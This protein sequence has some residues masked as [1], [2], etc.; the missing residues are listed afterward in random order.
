MDW[1]FLSGGETSP[2]PRRNKAFRLFLHHLY[3]FFN[4]LF[5]WRREVKCALYQAKEENN[6]YEKENIITYSRGCV[7]GFS[8]SRLR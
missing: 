1:F 8:Y 2:N 4:Y 5:F 6:Y 7:C 3:H